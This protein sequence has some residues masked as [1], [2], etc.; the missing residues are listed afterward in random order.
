MSYPKIVVMNTA[1]AERIIRSVL[2]KEELAKINKLL[3][4]KK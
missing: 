1:K 3:E 4:I 2:T